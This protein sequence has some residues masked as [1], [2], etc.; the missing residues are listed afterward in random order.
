MA[1]LNGFKD[2]PESGDIVDRVDV[3]NTNN[4]D[5]VAEIFF[6]SGKSIAFH[7][8]VKTDEE[9]CEEKNESKSA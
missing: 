5:N 6:T 4:M 2:F 1:I 7:Y 9:K 3:W 8:F